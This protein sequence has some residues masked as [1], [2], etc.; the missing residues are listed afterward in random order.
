MVMSAMYDEKKWDKG[1]WGVGFLIY[2]ACSGRP[3]QREG[4][5]EGANLADRWGKGIP[6]L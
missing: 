5:N 4:E 3:G 6:E 2:L 1:S